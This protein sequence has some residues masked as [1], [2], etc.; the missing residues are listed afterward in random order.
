MDH[1]RPSLKYVSA[2]DLEDQATKFAGL[3]VD[4][5]DG[6]KLGKLDGFIVDVDQNRPYHVVVSAGGWFSHKHFLLPV[7]H[8]ALD[9]GGEKLVADLTK[10]R[11]ERFP[12]FDRDNFEKL[13]S[14][15]L[16]QMADSMTEACCPGDVV[17]VAWEA[18]DHYRQPSWWN[19]RPASGATEP[20]QLGITSEGRR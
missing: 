10:D 7:G 1:P 16:K 15:D 11:V 8:V 3:E 20:G 2:K 14:A 5:T 4:G 12:G 17:V 13:S 18:A 6:E 19:D 9:D